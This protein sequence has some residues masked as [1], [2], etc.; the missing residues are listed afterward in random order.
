MLVEIN[1]ICIMVVVKTN[2]TNV[3]WDVGKIKC[4]GSQELV[5]TH[6][7]P[8]NGDT[9][10]D[11]APV[12]CISTPASRKMLTRRK[13]EQSKSRGGKGLLVQSL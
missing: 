1:G 6:L 13:T 2:S 3:D 10:K 5:A 7:L 12:P 4:K 9:I 11:C 8:W